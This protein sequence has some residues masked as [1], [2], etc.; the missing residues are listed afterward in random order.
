[1]DPDGRVN[2]AS[3]QRDL[4]FYASQGLVDSKIDVSRI[5]D[6]SFAIEAVKLLGPFKQ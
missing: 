5:V 6:M 2:T 1:M 4:D 3:L